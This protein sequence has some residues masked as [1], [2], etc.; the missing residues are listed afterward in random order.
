MDLPL[1]RPL[2]LKELELKERSG[3]DW[4]GRGEGREGGRGVG[5]NGGCLYRRR[6]IREWLGRM[7]QA[8]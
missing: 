3:E 8:V 2:A 1:T 5:E 7:V 4:R 6:E